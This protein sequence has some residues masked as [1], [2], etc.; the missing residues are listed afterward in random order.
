MKEIPQPSPTPEAQPPRSPDGKNGVTLLFPPQVY[1]TYQAYMR[2]IEAQIA[3]PPE[4]QGLTAREI[5][6]LAGDDLS[7]HA[8]KE[9]VSKMRD[10]LGEHGKI[11]STPAGNRENRIRIVLTANYPVEIKTSVRPG[12]R[13]LKDIPVTPNE[14][15]THIKNAP[16]QTKAELAKTLNLTLADI[17]LL[18]KNLPEDDK[19]QLK[20][21]RN[22]GLSA[23]HSPGIPPLTDSQRAA[24]RRA[25]NE[26]LKQ[27]GRVF[28]D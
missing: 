2:G 21:A 25:F 13:E 6:T 3:I 19:T 28:L 22:G 17:T 27:E 16:G 14:L 11:I 7:Y 26:R 1:V 4:N 15:F 20:Q 10:A 18:L 23:T 9:S 8:V 5:H 12:Q 24:M